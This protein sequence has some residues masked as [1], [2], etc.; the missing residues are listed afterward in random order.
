M[1]ASLYPPESDRKSLVRDPPGRFSP[2]NPAL[3]SPR[4]VSIDFL[5]VFAV[6]AIF[7]F[8]IGLWEKLPGSRWGEFAVAT[9][10]YLAGYCAVF[11][12]R[13]DFS[14]PLRRVWPAYFKS[15]FRAIYPTFFLI[16]LLLFVGSFLYAPD[17]VQ[18][19]YSIG[20]LLINLSLVTQWFGGQFFTGPMWFVPF[21]L[22]A[23][24]LM[25]W[26]A[27]CA[28]DWRAIPPVFLLSGCACAVAFLVNPQAATRI[29]RE[30]SP[31]FRLPELVIGCVL[32]RQAWAG[33]GWFRDGISLARDSSLTAQPGAAPETAALPG[34]AK[35]AAVYLLCSVV[36]A[37]IG[38]VFPTAA[39]VA[40]LPLRGAVVFLV[41]MAAAVV[42]RR[43]LGLD[44]AGPVVAARQAGCAKGAR[45]SRWL[46]LLA[47]ASFPFFLLHCAGIGFMRRHFSHNLWAWLGYWALCW[48]ASI[49]LQWRGPASLSV[50]RRAVGRYCGWPHKVFRAFI[51]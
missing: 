2:A 5:R 28:R 18:R 15:R 46:H 40:A 23:Y 12:S 45:R 10:V 20:E 22:Q 48:G 30:W 1:T 31:V 17:K 41:L 35:A 19:H 42:A 43:A 14:Q 11:Y 26:L 8:H 7:Y 16:T 9:F 25:P 4:N 36:A 6:N 44:G 38:L 51:A 34:G 49:L 29:C 21:V 13:I 32:A 47:S 37:A 24:A 50:L 27:R 33:R 39:Y 3:D